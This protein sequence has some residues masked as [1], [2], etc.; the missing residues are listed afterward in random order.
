VVVGTI[1]VVL[2]GAPLLSQMHFDF[3]PMHLQDPN[4]EA[5][6]TYRELSNVPEAAINS[7]EIIAPSVAEARRIARQLGARPEVAGTRTIDALVPTDQD[8]KL[9]LIQSAAAALGSAPDG[10]APRPAPSDA[11]NIEAIRVAARTIKAF[12]AGR[13]DRAGAARLES[14]LTRLADADPALRAKAQDALVMPLKLDLDRVRKMLKPVRIT[15]QTL[16][17][18]VAEDWLAAD[19]R[20]RVQVLPKGDPD[21]TVTLT[22]FAEAIVQAA[23]EAAGLPISMDA[24]RAHG[25]PGLYRGGH[26][27]GTGD[28][29]HPVDRVASG[30]RRTVDADATDRSRRGDPRTDRADRRT[31][32]LRQCDR[33][34]PVARSRRGVQDLLHHGMAARR[35]QPAAVDADPRRGFQRADDGNSIREPV[36]IEPAGHGDETSRA[37]RAWAS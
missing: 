36:A 12:G 32:Q 6:K 19:G 3:D 35:R 15:E 11:E 25:D 23:P 28:R 20:A 31:A 4:G 33:L 13:D 37:W 26:L 21:D 17:R 10:A 16:P 27:C 29:N 34:A 1:V 7:A 22:R 24:F 9:S 8:N 2:A 14:L 5:V 30:W 18:E